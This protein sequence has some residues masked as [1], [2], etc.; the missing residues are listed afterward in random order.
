MQTLYI[1]KNV[2][3]IKM[4]FYD[5]SQ[6][7]ASDFFVLVVFRPKSLHSLCSMSSELSCCLK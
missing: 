3:I 5:M 2:Y 6:H 7:D 1:N 4:M